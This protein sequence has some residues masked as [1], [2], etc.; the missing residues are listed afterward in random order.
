MKLLKENKLYENAIT[1]RQRIERVKAKISEYK[2]KYKR[3]AV[4]SHYYT[5]EYLGAI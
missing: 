1:Y 2:E 3:I 4:V 5:I